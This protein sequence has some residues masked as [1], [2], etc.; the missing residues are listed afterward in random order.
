MNRFFRISGIHSKL[1]ALAVLTVL[2]WPANSIQADCGD[3]VLILPSA[4]TSEAN[5]G[6]PFTPM[7]LPCTS[8]GCQAGSS[9]PIPLTSTPASKIQV[10]GKSLLIPVQ[11]RSLYLSTE[12]SGWQISD[13]VAS[14]QAVLDSIFHP[15]RHV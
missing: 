1:T 10:E 11:I 3:H 7:K 9:K 13:S 6:F 15:P 14:L 12:E 5:S 8:P 4:I 2:C